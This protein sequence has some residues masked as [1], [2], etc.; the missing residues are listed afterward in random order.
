MPLPCPNNIRP[1]ATNR[2]HIYCPRGENTFV[3]IGGF[4]RNFL[5]NI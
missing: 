2:N 3:K 4:S 5:V 1:V